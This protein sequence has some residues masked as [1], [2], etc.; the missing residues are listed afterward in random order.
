MSETADMQNKY[1][2]WNH[3][4]T[5]EDLPTELLDLI[6][7]SLCLGDCI[8]FRLTCK[9][10]ISMTPP[11]Q[12]NP[13]PMQ[14]ESGYQLPW[15]ISFPN[16]NNGV[17]NFYHPVSSDSYTRYIPELAGALLHNARYGWLLLSK[18]KNT[19]IF[20]F[21]PFTME[22][23][24][25]PDLKDR[26]GPFQNMFFSSPPTSSDFVVYG[27]S[28]HTMLVYHKAEN[29]WTTYSLHGQPRFE[30]FFIPCNP[31][32]H[33]GVFYFLCADGRLAL[34]NPKAIEEESQWEI[35]PES[36]LIIAVSSKR[37]FIVEYNG[38]IL[39]VFVGLLG[40]PISVFKLDHL[41]MKW[42][43]L[44]TLDD[45]AVFVSH[46]SSTMIPAGLKGIENRIYF[47]MLH[48]Q[49]NLFYSLSTRN[50][51]SFGSKD[52]R[53]DWLNTTEHWDCAW[54]HPTA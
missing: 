8:R 50:Y 47:P 9:S 46:K 26:D 35:F 6:S 34:F 44:E 14:P 43:R 16:N 24:N 37:N 53:E 5:W 3:E 38:E 41:K 13:L 20:L 1:D 2:D 32:F 45:K 11:L 40:K 28:T 31:I 21:N 23:V 54:I 7:S 29:T 52:S 49:D 51:H 30:I 48:G 12:S 42:D 19:C 10:W 25:L 39:A 4:R 18:N 36:A 17:C 33:G 15:L 27:L 22:L